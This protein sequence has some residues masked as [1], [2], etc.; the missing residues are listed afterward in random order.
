MEKL[1]KAQLESVKKLSTDAL[2]LKLMRVGYEEDSVSV[3]AREDLMDMWVDIVA[4]G[5]D[6]PEGAVAPEG[7]QSVG[8]DVEFERERLAFEKLKY[9]EEKHE[10]MRE[11]DRKEQE[12]ILKGKELELKAK[13]LRQEEEKVRVE[14]DK[15]RM[16]AEFRE[17]ETQRQVTR[18]ADERERNN[19][20]AVKIKTF[21][22]A[23]KNSITIQSDDQFE[24]IAFFRNAEH[25][26]DS[27][28]VPDNLRG[29]LIRPYLNNRSKEVVGRMDPIKSTDYDEIKGLILK[30]YKLSPAMYRESFNKLCKQEGETFTMFI[31]R[32][33]AVLSYYV[34]SRCVQTL[35]QMFELLVSDRVKTCLSESCL[36]HVL[37]VESATDMGWVDS[38]KL[39]QTIDCYLAN[40][41]GDKPKTAMLGQPVYRY[42]GTGGKGML[43]SFRTP[44]TKV[45]SGYTG[46]TS[47][48]LTNQK[49]RG[50]FLCGSLSHLKIDCDK[51]K[52][53]ANRAD[54]PRNVRHVNTCTAARD[55]CGEQY[56]S[57]EMYCKDNVSEEFVQPGSGERTGVVYS[58]DP[59]PPY[60]ASFNQG[61]VVSTVNEAVIVEAKDKMNSLLVGVNKPLDFAKLHYMNVRVA[62]EPGKCFQVVSAL[63][64]GGAEVAVAKPSTIMHCDY[65][66]RIGS[67][68]LRGIIGA[69]VKAELVR[70]YISLDCQCECK[71]CNQ[72][73][74]VMCAIC[75][76]AN[77]SLIL[78]AVNVDQL[79]SRSYQC[80]ALLKRGLVTF[81][82]S[83]PCK[84]V[85][86]SDGE[87]KP[88]DVVDNDNQLTPNM[89][90]VKD[91]NGVA[92]DHVDTEIVI[93]DSC[94]DNMMHVRASVEELICE[95][96]SDDSLKGAR[97]LAL[98]GKGGFFYKD[99]LLMH[100]EKLLGQEFTQLCLPLSRR[101][102]VLELGHEL[103]GH[104]GPK[105]T[106]QRI[107]L[108][109]YWCN[110][111]QDVK[112]HCQSCEL[113]Q[114][115]ARITFRDR[116]PI[117]PI[118][119]ADQAFSHWFMDVLGP[120]SSEKCEFNYCL[121]LVD[122]ATRYPAAFP[123][124]SI[125]AKSI[126]DALMSLFV[127]FGVAS[128]IS[129]DNAT[130]FSSRLNKEFVSRLG[131]SPRFS[132]C[133]HP[134]AN[135]LAERMVGTVKSSL[136]KMASDH[137]KS[138]HKYLG[139]VMWALREVPNETTGVA[140]WLLAFG[141]LPRGPLA[142]L[143]ETW[144][145]E[146]EFP[147]DL[148]KIPVD[149]LKELHEKLGI[150][151]LYAEAHTKGEQKRSTE[152]YNLRSK[153]KHF[154]V[155]DKVL[156]LQ[157]DSTA[158][159]LH[160]KWKGPAS[161]VEVRSPY[162]YVVELDGRR[163]RLHANQL[164]PF[165]VR[166]V[167]IEFDTGAVTQPYVTNKEECVV[168]TCAIIYDHDRDFGDIQTVEKDELLLTTVDTRLMSLPSERIDLS[169][170]DH[171]P[172]DRR[173]EILTI[174]D[175]FP[176]VFSD[177]PGFCNMVVHNIPV[178][179][180]FKPKRLQA[181]RVPER[182]KPEVNKQLNDLLKCGFIKPSQS[183]MASPLVCVLKG[184][185][186]EGGVRLAIDYR[187]LNKFTV[188]DAFPMPDMAEVIQRIGRACY[189]ST[190]DACSGYWQT[191][192]KPSDQWLSAFVCDKGLFEWTR[193]AFGMKS[194]GNTF[195]RAVQCILQP[196][197]SFTDSYI[198]DMA[199]YSNEWALHLKHLRQFLQRVRESGLTLKLCKCK[200]ALPEVK[201]CGEIVGSGNRRADPDKVT[202]VYELKVPTT[203]TQVRQVLGI[204]G[205][206][207]DH[208]P[209]YA[210]LAK[211]LTDLT[212]K[213]VNNR[214]PWGLVEQQAFD[215][216]KD[217]LCKS[218]VNPLHIID[219]L[220]PFHLYV[221]ASDH[222]V[223]GVLTQWE[224]KGKVLPVAFSSQKLNAT[225]RRWATVEKEAYAALTMLRKFR[226]WV[227]GTKVTVHSDHN[228]LLYLT[229]SAPKSAKLMRWA[230]A[231]QEFDI[232][233]CYYA[234]KLNVAADTLTRMG[235]D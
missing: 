129:S 7:K 100:R 75:E 121:V 162:S 161:V 6:K 8:Y 22:D 157:P 103:G 25:L 115:K 123:L 85:K 169:K 143:K 76:E 13:E 27:L 61:D 223:A 66:E 113:C 175:D 53:R 116:V 2:R 69:P 55:G 18:D 233:F 67:I 74:P 159:R 81:K 212:G 137:P 63:D 19:S 83:K 229:E 122:S 42:E 21:G 96:Q 150:A 183:P 29:T 92:F 33:K 16:E 12:L 204:F 168:S 195:V 39:G 131:C 189:I 105:R 135:G 132:S 11:N 179:Q 40:H 70:L 221:D 202:A 37:S 188:A 215:E 218:A 49:P 41:V 57:L 118:P 178:S 47:T 130:N 79:R 219:L 172:P 227:W 140:P 158:S 98:K 191:A 97:S 144:C 198:D 186:G 52:N 217:V 205:Y 1:T 78:T 126:C 141:H 171:L 149:Y 44:Y 58:S 139:F 32:L 54:T 148:G 228:P 235:P 3:L 177:S 17:R 160:S 187:Y 101:P 87:E 71:P 213:R 185:D 80:N 142:V 106:G 110:V 104:L 156:I 154:S 181:Y 119:R 95:Q 62:G 114:K 226:C 65:V 10:R 174:L 9:E 146:R 23:L 190:F 107:R 180:D 176:D 112:L 72:W 26:F 194:S 109:F 102:K 200:F 86:D 197:K 68:T 124:R 225:Q 222:T 91:V 173:R 14:G 209:N 196:V 125:T 89:L 210:M 59:I 35:N 232:E 203:K 24:T 31:S 199:V 128:V 192:I 134:Q 208:I 206:F 108:S 60:T 82:K 50:C 170:L 182:L 120:I 207:R 152:R 34:E 20:M 211:P 5:K 84:H 117:H 231:L 15:A 165:Y 163:Y 138:W 77:D 90:N 167:T 214:V 73:V 145:G 147:L 93:N 220:R 136:S 155:N 4:A 43:T 56:G 99:K 51:N 28:M 48:G 94:T 45:Q 64:D 111:N 133:Y 234:G 46:H 30:E 151:K 38:T 36:R 164:R 193:T 230:L 153:D 166:A 88:V 184:K 201:F 216:L 224:S 127:Y